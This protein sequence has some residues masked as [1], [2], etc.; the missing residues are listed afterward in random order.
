MSGAQTIKLGTSET[1]CDS[2]L[3]DDA[4]H[5]HQLEA[6]VEVSASGF[7]QMLVLFCPTH[8]P[9]KRLYSAKPDAIF[10]ALYPEFFKQALGKEIQQEPK[11]ARWV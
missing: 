5:P 7:A 11:P 1:V 2:C 4:Q 6:R 9:V 10:K 3:A 8:G